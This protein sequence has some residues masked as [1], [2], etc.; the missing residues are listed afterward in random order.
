M[1]TNTMKYIFI[2]NLLGVVDVVAFSYKDGQTLGDSR[3]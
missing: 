1:T 3:S 2:M